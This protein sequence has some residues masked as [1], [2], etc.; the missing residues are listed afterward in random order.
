MCHV[1]MTFLSKSISTPTGCLTITYPLLN[2][3]TVIEWPIK[4]CQ[5][6]RFHLVNIHKGCYHMSCYNLNWPKIKFWVQYFVFSCALDHSLFHLL[7]TEFFWTA[8][9]RNFCSKASVQKSLCPLVKKSLCSL[10]QKI[11]VKS[12]LGVGLSSWKPG[13]NY[14]LELKQNMHC[15]LHPWKQN[16]LFHIEQEPLKLFSSQWRTI[17][18][19]H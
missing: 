14:L 10:V 18:S 2:V 7:F 16:I 8:G 13:I 5:F 15:I 3:N 17:P 4:W 9:Y 19:S 1:K 6:G 11:S 12:R